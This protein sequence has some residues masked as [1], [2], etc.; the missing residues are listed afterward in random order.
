MIGIPVK[1]EADHIGACLDALAQQRGVQGHQVVLLVN[2]TTD[3]T[4]EAAQAKQGTL[5]LGIHIIE[6]HLPPGQANAGHARRLAMQAAATLAGPNGV[7]LSTDADGRPAPDWLLQNLAALDGGADA[8]AGRA[9]LAPEDVARIPARLHEDDRRECAYS[10]ALEEIAARLDPDLNDPWPRHAEHSGAS[11]CAKASAF[12]LCG[13]IPDVASGEDRAFFECLRRH[14]AVI[15]HAPEVRV[16][17][18]GRIWGRAK[19]GM[20]DTI[21]RRL[22]APDPMLDDRLEPVTTWALRYRLRAQARRAWA[23]PTP[24]ALVALARLLRMPSAAVQDAFE[25]PW[26]GMAWAALETESPA[27]VKQPVAV[28]DL[29]REMGHAVRFRTHLRQADT[30]VLA[31]HAMH[32]ARPV[33]GRAAWEPAA[34]Q[35]V[36]LAPGPALPSPSLIER[37]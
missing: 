36:L 13:G 9:E 23:T 14:D 7:L 19:G 35:P 17:V 24:G 11:I 34:A 27:L 4:V 28:A 12:A 25:L 15:R 32:L 18:S 5:G 10:D 6:R 22:A 26:L 16:A 3:A 29:P 37:A 30:A 1:D 20:A 31:Q 8:V 2:N 33:A 21:R